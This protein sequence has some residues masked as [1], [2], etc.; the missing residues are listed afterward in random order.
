MSESPERAD[1]SAGGFLS[2]VPWIRR[3][4]TRAR[5]SGSESGGTT[6][7]APA[8]SMESIA[9]NRERDHRWVRRVEYVPKTFRYVRGRGAQDVSGG[10]IEMDA[11]I[12]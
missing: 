9:V 11:R 5:R 3:F 10:S 8:E 4:A 1:E 12:I 6:P 2:L 7:E